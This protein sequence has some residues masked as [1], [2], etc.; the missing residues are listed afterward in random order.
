MIVKKSMTKKRRASAVI[1]P[2]ELVK[3][4]HG[5][6]AAV[7]VDGRFLIHLQ[8]G[9]ER[10][11]ENAEK[12]LTVLNAAVAVVNNS[13]WSGVCDEDTALEKALQDI[14]PSAGVRATG[15]AR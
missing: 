11:G 14:M 4:D 6:A 12:L 15:K 13:A 10:N 1:R 3:D 8:C 7:A 9:T 5:Y 2:F